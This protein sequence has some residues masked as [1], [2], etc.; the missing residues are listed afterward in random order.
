MTDR[1][2]ALDNL[3]KQLKRARINMAHAEAKYDGKPELRACQDCELRNIQ[4][5]I[6]D[7]EAEI[8]RVLEEG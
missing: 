7:I 8:A 3:Y 4:R 1:I 6:D 5:K 2:T